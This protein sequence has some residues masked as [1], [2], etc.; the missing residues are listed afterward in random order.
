[1]HLKMYLSVLYNYLLATFLYQINFALNYEL[2]KK[3]SKYVKEIKSKFPIIY[4]MK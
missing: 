2:K 1:M 3:K 4:L